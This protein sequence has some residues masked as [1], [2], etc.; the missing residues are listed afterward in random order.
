MM[1]RKKRFDRH[2]NNSLDA[3]HGN[4]VRGYRIGAALSPG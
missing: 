1:V 2:F 3:C 4:V